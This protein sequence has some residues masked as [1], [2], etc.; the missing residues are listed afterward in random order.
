MDGGA[1]EADKW[2]E[3]AAQKEKEW[4]QATE[5]RLIK[6]ICIGDIHTTHIHSFAPRASII[7]VETGPQIRVRN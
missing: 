2:R 4:K 1:T 5:Q 6:F 7:T 3:I